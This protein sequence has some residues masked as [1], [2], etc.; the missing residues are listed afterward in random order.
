MFEAAQNEIAVK[1]RS[2]EKTKQEGR[3]FRDDDIARHENAKHQKFKN[4]KS[5]AIEELFHVRL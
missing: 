4:Q 2:P 1:G 3:G 5:A